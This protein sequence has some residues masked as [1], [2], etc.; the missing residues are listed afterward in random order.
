LTIAT[1]KPRASS[2]A[3]RD[4]AAM[5]FPNEETTPPVTKTNRAIEETAA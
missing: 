3:P 4:A 1:R 5:P 2:I